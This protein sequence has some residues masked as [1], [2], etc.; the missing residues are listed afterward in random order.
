MG[1]NNADEVGLS[2]LTYAEE[3][4]PDLDVQIDETGFDAQKFTTRAASGQVPDL[5]QMDRQFVATYAAQDL[6]VPLDDCFSAHDVDPA[7]QYYESVTADVVYDGSTWGISQFYQPPAILLNTRVMEAA[8]VTPDQI[9]TSQ[10]DAARRREEDVHRNGR[11][12]RRARL[13]PGGR[14]SGGAVDAEL[15]RSHDRRGG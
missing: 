10:P 6:I 2:R 5:V 12:S 3:Q 4:L 11:Q 13:R 1:F 7:T 14:R 15:R 9:D 8:G